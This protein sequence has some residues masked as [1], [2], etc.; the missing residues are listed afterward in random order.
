[1]KGGT[2]V[3]G[4]RKPLPVLLD[5]SALAHDTIVVNGGR[6]GLQ[7]ELSPHDL[8]RATEGRTLRLT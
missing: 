4:S 5:E 6:R 7:L 2:S 3:F 1:M 8:L